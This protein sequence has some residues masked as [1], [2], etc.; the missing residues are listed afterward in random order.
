[1]SPGPPSGARIAHHGARLALLLG[2]ATLITALFPPTARLAV[3]RYEVGMVAPEDVIARIPFSVPK[4]AEEMAADKKLTMES[5]PPTFDYVADAADTMA[6]RLRAFFDRIDS[7]ASAGDRSGVEQA[8][9]EAR[10]SPRPRRW[11]P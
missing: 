11:T 3:G 1:M 9:R 4:S 2:L 5:V 6:T 8:L 10:S 7:A